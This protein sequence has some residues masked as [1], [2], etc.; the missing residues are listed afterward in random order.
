MSGAG[1]YAYLAL[2]HCAEQRVGTGLQEMVEALRPIQFLPYAAT[3][4]TEVFLR[5]PQLD[6]LLTWESE[7]LRVTKDPQYGEFTIVYPS[8]SL[9]IEVVV[10]IADAQVDQRG[11]RE[12]AEDYLRFFYSPQGQSMIEQAGFRPRYPQAM[13]TLRSPKNTVQT[14]EAIFGSWQNALDRHLGPN[15]SLARFL[16]YRKARSG[17]TE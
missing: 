17:G 14:V 3:R 16:E 7:A 10:A 6:A 8:F 11:T 13:T 1:Q 15:G 2:V 12:A 5:D 4:S 9:E